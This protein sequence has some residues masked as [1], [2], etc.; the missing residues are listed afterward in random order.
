MEEL[1]PLKVFQDN[2]GMWAVG[3]DLPFGGMEVLEWFE[4]KAE[5]EVFAEDQVENAELS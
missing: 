1:V 3:F 4:T 2:S 5:A